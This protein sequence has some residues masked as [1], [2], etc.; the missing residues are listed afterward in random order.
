MLL[1]LSLAKSPQTVNLTVRVARRYGTTID[2]HHQ[3][4]LLL[5]RMIL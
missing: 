2:S 3:L 4:F 5:C 1:L